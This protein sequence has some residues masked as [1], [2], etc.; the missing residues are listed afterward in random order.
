MR[1]RLLLVA[2]LVLWPA[3]ASADDLA[4][5]KRRY[6]FLPVP[7]IGGDSD[8]GVE[9]GVSF[10]L[11]RF[12]DDY[13]PYKWML[14]GLFATSFKDDAQGFRAVLQSHNLTLDL[15]D[16]WD[17][18]LRLI[19][20]ANF[21]REIDARWYGVGN[22]TTPG[23]GLGRYNEYIDENTGVRT[24][25]RVKTG[26]VVDGA[27]GMNLRYR[28]PGLYGA[29]TK[30]ADDTV[31]H[32]IPG[33]ANAFLGTVAAG[34]VIDTRDDE[35][36]PHRGVYDQIGVAETV[37][38]AERVVYTE[39][40]AVLSTFIPIAKRVT[41][42]TRTV[43]SLKFGRVPF[44]DLQTGGVFNPQPLLGSIDGVRGVRL[45]RYAGRAKLIANYEIRT[46]PIPSF[47]V[48]SYKLQIGTVTFFDCGR[49]W[50]DYSSDLAKADG[51]RLGI[52]WGA[53][54]GLF[55]RFDKSSIFR[56]E[57]AY[58]PDENETSFY[59]ASGLI[60]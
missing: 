5:Q 10:T 6:E 53:G 36:L 24:F 23:P 13:Y 35:F 48:L 38:S 26:T 45:G 46:T 51:T 49:V 19:T 8:I 54:G 41:F 44:Y 29:N 47:K 32:D 12:Y 14:Q 33:A 21:N 31:N 30:L 2:A 15:V 37:G 60:F 1:T 43:A 20:T 42:A 28:A 55:F 40:S 57:A 56:V 18:R 50:S 9:V 27:F 34:V 3:V 11:A 7:D 52:K 4:E 58:S 25:G 17:R 59:V 16:L 22:A 39:T